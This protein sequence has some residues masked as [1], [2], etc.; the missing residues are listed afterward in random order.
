VWTDD[1]RIANIRAEARRP[2]HYGW[3]ATAKSE[4]PGWHLP[5]FLSVFD[6]SRIPELARKYL[7]ALHDQERGEPQKMVA[8]WNSTLALGWEYSGELPEEDELRERAEPYR[9]WTTPSGGLV[10]LMQVDVQHDRLAVTVWAIG[11]GEEMWLTYW[12]ELFGRTIVPHEGA[13]K[14]LEML[15]Q[16]RVENA[17]GTDMPITAVGIDSGDGQTSDAV[18]DFVRKHHR[19]DRPIFATRGAPDKIGR[20]EIWTRSKDIDPNARATKASRYGVKQHQVGAAKAKDL[21]LGWAMEG[22]R[23]RLEGSGPGRMHWYKGV[24]D[25]F[26]EQLLGEMKIPHRENPRVRSWEPRT[27]RRNEVLDC[28]VIAVWMCRHLR[29]HLKRAAE[30]DAIEL[31]LRQVPLPGTDV[32]VTA[33]RPEATTPAARTDDTRVP[34]RQATTTRHAP[35][36][37][38]PAGAVAQAVGGASRFSGAGR[39]GGNGGRR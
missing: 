6:G 16:R 34:E 1:Q 31:R 33:L 17:L 14:E 35:V 32:D 3:H 23:V 25:D 15:L 28:T 36:A 26:F 11:R 19:R 2:P 22:G 10:A 5:E 20:V 24:R 30:W 7:V 8:F 18:F 9:E 12:G 27:D 13:W 21:I 4:V 29:L 37:P 38:R 39:F